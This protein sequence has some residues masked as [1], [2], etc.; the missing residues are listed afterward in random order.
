MKK[1]FRA[2]DWLTVLLFLGLV[3]FG[4]FNIYSASLGERIP[5]K[6]FDFNEFYSKQLVW[7]GFS[8]FLA[9]LI[10]SIEARFFVRFSSIIYLIS[11][12]S[13]LGLFV[14]G[15]TISGQTAWY[16]FGSFSIQPAEFVKATTTL[17]MAKYL[18]DIQTNIKNIRHQSNAFIIIFIPAVLILLQPDPGS[19]LIYL[20]FIFPLYR[21]GLSSGY[22]I[23]GFSVIA[24]FVFTLLYG[25]WWVSLGVILLIGSV[26]FLGKALRHTMRFSAIALASI[27]FSFS[28]NF[29][30]YNVFKQH[31]RDRFDVVLGKTSDLKGIGYNT[32]Q[33]IV[34]IGSGGWS[35]KGWRE[36][37]QTSGNFVPEQHTDYIFSTVGEEWGFLGSAAVIIAFVILIARLLFLAERQKS[38]FARVYGYGVAGIF[39]IH[40]AVNIGMV[41]GILPTVGIPLPFLSYGG[42]SLWG[43]T[44]LLFIFLKLDAD[45][46]LATGV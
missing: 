6:F 38:T 14:F 10:L 7:I 20:A 27:V 25:P 33:S 32:H 8:L 13:L 18:S 34:A 15:K 41:I 24:L 42:S 31:H 39:F 4:W 5:E 1:I 35:G 37:T 21:E 46:K 17:A 23:F 26:L 2:P 11:L 19:A 30:F 44:I 43:F 9:I 36:G 40:F 22:L 12:I 16:A 3:A 29:I 28:V 45:R